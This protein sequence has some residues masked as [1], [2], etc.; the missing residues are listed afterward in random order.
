[1]GGFPNLSRHSPRNAPKRIAKIFCGNPSS[2]LEIFALATCGGADGFCPTF[3]TDAISTNPPP[4]RA[5]PERS[6]RAS[7]ESAQSPA[8]FPLHPP[9]KSVPLLSHFP[10]P[11]EILTVPILHFAFRT[12]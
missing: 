7:V 6:Y 1:M 9:P 2:V 8:N 5:L 4:A 3:I 10:Q 11:P 12:S